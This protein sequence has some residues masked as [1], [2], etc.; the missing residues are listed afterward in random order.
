MVEVWLDDHSDRP[1]P[2][3]R[4]SNAET[5]Q[6]SPDIS[7]QSGWK[8]RG[9]DMRNGACTSDIGRLGRDGRAIIAGARP[10]ARWQLDR[11]GQSI[12]GCPVADIEDFNGYDAAPTR[13][14]GATILTQLARDA[15][16]KADETD[17][18]EIHRVPS[19]RRQATGYCAPASRLGRE[20]SQTFSAPLVPRVPPAAATPP[21]WWLA[22]QID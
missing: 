14:L 17:G 20:N 6:R 5:M 13:R 21:P 9:N 19:A 18:P 7:R 8:A 12:R 3:G 2:L 15:A 4:K 16:R 22:G 10:T 1:S 11:S